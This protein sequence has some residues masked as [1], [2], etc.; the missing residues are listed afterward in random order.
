METE[1]RVGSS[2]RVPRRVAMTSVMALEWN[3]SV[4]EVRTGETRRRVR[5]LLLTAQCGR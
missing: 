4:V 1:D 3:R 2:W 5:F